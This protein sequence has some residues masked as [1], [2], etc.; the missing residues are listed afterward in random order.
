[1]GTP[2][3]LVV[4]A[5]LGLEVAEGMSAVL[6]VLIVQRAMRRI[7]VTT[8]IVATL[9]ITNA[10]MCIIQVRLMKLRILHSSLVELVA[11]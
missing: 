2:V 10:P 1:M 4:H 6:L 7:G 8:V 9:P 11:L 3:P 5:F